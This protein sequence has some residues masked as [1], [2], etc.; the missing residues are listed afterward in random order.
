M[1]NKWGCYINGN[2]QVRINLENGTKIRENDL[3]NFTPEFPEC[4]DFKITNYC[5]KSCP[6]CHEDSSVDGI[7]GDIMNLKFVDTL[8]PY[9]ELAIG[10][11]N[12]LAHPDLV[13]FLEKCKELKIISNLTVNQSH[14]VSQ[15][16]L[17]KK[18]LDEKLIY[19]LGVSVTGDISDIFEDIKKYPN[20]VLHTI[21][22][23]MSVESYRKLY[24]KNLKVL[25][26]GYKHF[27]RGNDFYSSTVEQNQRDLFEE[28]PEMI[29]HFK[30]V[31]FDNLAISQLDARRLMSKEKWDEFYMGD[32]GKYTMYIDGVNKQYVRSSVSTVRK[33]L[34]DNIK[35]MFMDVRGQ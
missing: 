7:H 13:P 31:S 22:G 27:R 5:D 10:G 18:L 8:M 21:C 4:I 6:Y 2:Y 11:G 14:F 25:I 33:D 9:T 20:I 16:E 15:N 3:D 30:V 23:V 32:D 35:D 24:D 1:K 34:L 17:V 29:K 19:G 26:L 12:P 28:L